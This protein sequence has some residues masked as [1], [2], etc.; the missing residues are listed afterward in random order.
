MSSC[1][2]REVNL[3]PEACNVAE[4][5]TVPQGAFVKCQVVVWI[6]VTVSTAV[7]AEKA[8]LKLLADNIFPW[9]TSGE[10]GGGYTVASIHDRWLSNSCA[11]QWKLPLHLPENFTTLLPMLFTAGHHMFSV[12]ASSELELAKYKVVVNHLDP[13]SSHILRGLVQITA[14]RATDV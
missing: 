7:T 9:S 3:R 5:C 2:S 8:L 14:E 4:S 6:S 12:G 11:V 1:G 10:T 13:I